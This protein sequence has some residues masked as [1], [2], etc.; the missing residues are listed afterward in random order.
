MDLSES[1]E[2]KK[3][4][5]NKTPPTSQF[6]LF[7][8]TFLTFVFYPF[9]RIYLSSH[10]DGSVLDRCLEAAV[11]LQHLSL[12][13]VWLYKAEPAGMRVHVRACHIW[14]YAPTRSVFLCLP[15]RLSHLKDSGGCRNA[16]INTVALQ[17]PFC[18]SEAEPSRFGL[19]TDMAMC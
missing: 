6:F 7:L 3:K 8:I 12:R 1:P 9:V 5:Q 17:L 15:D 4:P 13:A 11:P 2:A 14:Y 19:M 10:W 18:A 16:V